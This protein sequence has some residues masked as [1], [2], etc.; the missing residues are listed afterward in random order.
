MLRLARVWRPG[1]FRCG[2]LTG[3]VL[4]L[5]LGAVGLLLAGRALSVISAG[6]AAPPGG[7]LR[8]VQSDPGTPVAGNPAGTVTLTEFFDYRCPYCRIMQ[9]RVDALL[10]RDKRVRLVLKEWPIFGGVSVYA[11]RVALAAEWQGK[12][13]AVHQALFALPRAMDEASVRAAAAAAGVDLMRLDH[14][15]AKRGDEINA[16]LLQTDREARSLGL[17]GTPG[18]IVGSTLVPGAMSEGDLEKLVDQPAKH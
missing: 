14:D 11:A 6:H 10:A 4:V 12:Y 5:G 15:L 17:Q 16:A 8:Q 2:R 18:F 9:P 3:F 7:L 1:R 13:D